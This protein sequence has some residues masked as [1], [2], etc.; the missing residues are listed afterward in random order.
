MRRTGKVYQ[1]KIWKFDV[2][3]T[4]AGEKL[5]DNAGLACSRTVNRY[6][7]GVDDYVNTPP[8]FD[9]KNVNYVR[10][11][12]GTPRPVALEGESNYRTSGSVDVGTMQMSFWWDWGRLQPGI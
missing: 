6:R 7:K 12:D 3:P 11:P 2:N 1:T 4:S 10:D 8:L 5:L 9:W